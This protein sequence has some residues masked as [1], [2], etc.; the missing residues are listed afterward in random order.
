MKMLTHM[1]KVYHMVVGTFEQGCKKLQRRKADFCSF[2]VIGRSDDYASE[3][4][5][6]LCCEQEKCMCSSDSGERPMALHLTRPLVENV[7]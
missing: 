6:L 1:H 3:R 7:V 2:R 4:P 5:M